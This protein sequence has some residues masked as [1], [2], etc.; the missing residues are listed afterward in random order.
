MRQDSAP[1]NLETAS[2]ELMQQKARELLA[3]KLR[4]LQKDRQL[5]QEAFNLATT[6]QQQ[7]Q[8]RPNSVSYPTSPALNKDTPNEQWQTGRQSQ[9]ITS[10]EPQGTRSLRRDRRY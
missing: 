3:M 7:R 6:A 1:I 2:A 9:T 8:R 10:K 4:E 5:N